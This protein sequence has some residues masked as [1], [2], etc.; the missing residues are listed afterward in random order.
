M[1]KQIQLKVKGSKPFLERFIESLREH[2]LVILTSPIRHP[3]GEDP[4]IYI[5]VV[6]A[7]R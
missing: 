6:E 5:T 7:S 2:Y 4:F 3:P 1:P